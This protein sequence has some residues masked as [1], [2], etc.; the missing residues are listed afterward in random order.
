MRGISMFSSLFLFQTFG[1]V[2]CTCAIV[3]SEI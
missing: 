2:A 1:G 3:L